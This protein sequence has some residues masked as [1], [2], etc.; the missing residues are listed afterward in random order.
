MRRPPGLVGTLALLSHG[1]KLHIANPERL[2]WHHGRVGTY[3]G[4]EWPL[5]EHAHTW[6]EVVD[7]AE[8]CKICLRSSQA[9]EFLAREK[10]K[11]FW[12]RFRSR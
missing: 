10:H 5:P 1:G 3:C 12:R 2:D 7:E 9:A 6:A 4:R 8:V 11:H